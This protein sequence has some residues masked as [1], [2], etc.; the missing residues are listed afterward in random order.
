MALFSVVNLSTRV[1]SIHGIVTNQI[2]DFFYK[3]T[4]HKNGV[5]S[6]PMFHLLS[7]SLVIKGGTDLFSFNRFVVSVF[8]QSKQ[9]NWSH[10][11]SLTRITPCDVDTIQ[12]D[13]T[14][15]FLFQPPD[16]DPMSI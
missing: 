6:I 13:A 9:S 15:K 5:Y 2:Y 4:I 8:V 12:L 1:N 10:T 14:K 11:V 7:R 16:I 3:L